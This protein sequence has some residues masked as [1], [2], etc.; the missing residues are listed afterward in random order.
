MTQ[1]NPEQCQ[2]DFWSCR[3]SGGTSSGHLNSGG[4]SAPRVADS[5]GVWAHAPPRGR[6]WK[7]WDRERLTFFFPSSPTVTCKTSKKHN[8]P[9]DFSLLFLFF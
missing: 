2:A 4:A 6:A 8:R 1:N 5:G 3:N 7:R 9:V